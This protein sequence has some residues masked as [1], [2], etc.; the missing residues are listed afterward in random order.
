MISYVQYGIQGVNCEGLHCQQ[1]TI[2]SP[3]IGMQFYTTL[4]TGKP[5]LDI[6][7]NHIAAG[8]YGILVNEMVQYVISQ[9]LIYLIEATPL[10]GTTCYGIRLESGSAAS[11]VGF[12]SIVADNILICDDP[13]GGYSV[14]KYGIYVAGGTGT[15]ESVLIKGNKSEA[16]TTALIYLDSSTEKVVVE[17]DNISSSDDPITNAG[18]G[19][20]SATTNRLA[21][22]SYTPTL[23]R[24]TNIAIGGTTAYTCYWKR[25]GTVVTV[26]GQFDADPTAAGLCEVGMSLPIP[27][28]LSAASELGGSGAINAGGFATTEFL[29]ISADAAN[30]TALMRWNAALIT[31]NGFN[32]IFQYPII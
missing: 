29:N 32:F 12:N 11:G 28:T 18:T 17:G 25:T 10:S 13:G 26:S 2:L 8:S 20:T 30:D 3:D 22:G 31:N 1:N 14:A 5:Y 15:K 16:F 19:A 23:T 27:S 24:V 9:N 7:G 21:S 6:T 4:T